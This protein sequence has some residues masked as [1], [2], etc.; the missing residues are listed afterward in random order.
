M[1]E[2]PWFQDEEVDREVAHQRCFSW[3][4]IGMA[5]LLGI[6][7]AFAMPM[8]GCAAQQPPP[9]CEKYT[10]EFVEDESGRVLMAIDAEN[11]KKLGAIIRGLQNG[12]CRV[13]MGT[14]I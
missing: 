6:T 3:R 4:V 12:T 7:L 13:A 5:I 10:Y 11:S 8:L 1:Q 2:T 14:E 9:L